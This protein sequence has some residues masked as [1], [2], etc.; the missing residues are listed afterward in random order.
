[1][2][3]SVEGKFRLAVQSALLAGFA[4]SG[5]A[6]MAQD[7]GGESSNSVELEKIEVTGSRLSRSDV[8]GALPVTVIDRAQIE[9]T[10]LPSVADVIRTQSFNSFG[11][12]REVSGDS[13]TGQAQASMRGLGA[14]R[15]LILIDG[16][17]VPP[18]PVAGAGGADLNTIPLAAVERIEILQDGA[19]AIY[20]SDAIGGVINIILRKDINGVTLSAMGTSPSRDGG[21]EQSASLVG[22]ISN[23][24]TRIVYGISWTD[25]NHVAL[26]DRKY[27]SFNPGDGVN[28]STVTGANVVGNTLYGY[29]SHL[30]YAAPSC[31]PS[32]VY[33]YDA[34]GSDNKVCIYPYANVA[35]DTMDLRNTS[36]FLNGDQ[37]ITDKL[38]AFFQTTYS[39]VE[40]LGRFAAVPGGVPLG[41]DVDTN[42]LG[43]TPTSS[44]A[45]SSLA[46]VTT[47]A[48]T[49]SS[50]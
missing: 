48:P 18:S 5:Q 2:K 6:A 9:A 17:R 42:P 12:Y 41:A 7:T 1:M 13:F 10:G 23:D 36:F 38:S 25:R 50:R 27:T 29:D 19:S 40:T 45:S 47:T 14:E 43:Q 39:R 8:E 15:T 26:A 31:D 32:R 20:G 24:K 44:T 35:W 49:R 30:Y 16:R 46:H 21:A 34:I 37:K 22:G 28:F 33:T 4:L 3:L 11:S